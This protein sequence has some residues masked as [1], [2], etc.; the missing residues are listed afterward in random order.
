MTTRIMGTYKSTDFDD[1]WGAGYGSSYGVVSLLPADQLWEIFDKVQ[2]DFYYPLVNGIEDMP[3]S[4]ACRINPFTRWIEI[5]V[6][7]IMQDG[8]VD[9]VKE[10]VA[11]EVGHMQVMPRTYAIWL[12]LK[13]GSIEACNNDKVAGE[14][15]NIFAD[16]HVNRFVSSKAY[17]TL[18]TPTKV[19]STF[20]D[21]GPI[22]KKVPKTDPPTPPDPAEADKQKARL[23]GLLCHQSFLIAGKPS[24]F[25]DK[26]DDDIK[27]DAVQYLQ[28]C[29]DESKPLRQRVKEGSLIVKKY[30]DVDENG[31]PKGDGGLGD[32]R[33][34]SGQS[35]GGD[36]EHDQSGT[37][38]DSEQRMGL[39]D[40]LRD[41]KMD[42][43]RGLGHDLSQAEHIHLT[44]H[45]MLRSEALEMVNFKLSKS[46]E[47]FHGMIAPLYP[48]T[49]SLG[50]DIEELDMEKTIIAGGGIVIPN[51]TTRRV[52][53]KRGHGQTETRIPKTV[54]VIDTS[55][56]M[57]Q[58]VA[59]LSTFVLI[60]A[61]RKEKGKV[62]IIA[63]SECA[64]M[65]QPVTDK[66]D[67]VEKEFFDKYHSGGTCFKDS[68][69]LLDKYQ[70][71]SP[72]NV[73]MVTD[74]ETSQEDRADIIAKL[75][76]PHFALIHTGNASDAAEIKTQ[77]GGNVVHLQQLKEL[78]AKMCE[79]YERQKRI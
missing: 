62:G 28:I 31:N 33:R 66:Y 52:F 36:S 50:D 77:S 38:T 76:S 59:T 17:D 27:K 42:P 22:P 39:A 7:H 44:E 79:I 37:M 68:I 70:K 56:S 30:L 55:G 57:D 13:L 32:A 63:F 19:A 72:A 4:K 24:P 26:L 69:K 58:R 61:H 51:V 46:I 47:T 21:P 3:M 35:H 29:F 48:L 20:T 1:Y 23:I 67:D 5:D 2:M 65:S 9:H 12:D 41:H 6:N 18:I 43:T 16:D 74:M 78:P 60:E 64:W 8:G 49:W 34:K 14:L 10:C 25:D 54:C 73:I 53:K 71:K 15:A 40:Y 45:D 11:H 75:N